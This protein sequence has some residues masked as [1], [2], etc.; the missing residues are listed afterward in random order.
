MFQNSA[1]LKKNYKTN[2]CVWGKHSFVPQFSKCVGNCPPCPNSL[3]VPGAF[4]LNK[5]TLLKYIRLFL[6]IQRQSVE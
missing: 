4:V 2:V 6:W 5:E 1:F 3:Y